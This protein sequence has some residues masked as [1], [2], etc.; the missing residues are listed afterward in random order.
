MRALGRY[1]IVDV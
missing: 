1:Q